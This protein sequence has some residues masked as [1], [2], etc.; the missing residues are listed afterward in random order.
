MPHTNTHISTS[1]THTHHKHHTYRYIAHTQT[2]TTRTI[3]TYIQHTQHTHILHTTHIVHIPHKNTYTH[4]THTYAL[5][6]PTYKHIYHTCVWLRAR[7]FC[8]PCSPLISFFVPR[9]HWDLQD[10]NLLTFKIP[11]HGHHWAGLLATCWC[12]LPG[13]EATSS[14][15]KPMLGHNATSDFLK[16]VRGSLRNSHSGAGQTA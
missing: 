8:P 15:R 5:H 9:S 4:I 10:K 14:P 6:V 2:H 11:K 13:T 12:W 3:D 7:A 16:D 1:C